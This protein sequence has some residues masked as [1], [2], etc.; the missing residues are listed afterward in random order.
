MA[1]HGGC[2]WVK[3]IKGVICIAERSYKGVIFITERYRL[4]VRR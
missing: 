1:G 3:W 2:S 4:S